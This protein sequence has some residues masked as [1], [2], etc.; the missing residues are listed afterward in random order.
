MATTL[1][2]ATIKT[3]SYDMRWGGGF[4]WIVR[5]VGATTALATSEQASRTEAGAIKAAQRWL[6]RQGAE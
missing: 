2:S 4:G 3:F 5:R 6:A 1:A